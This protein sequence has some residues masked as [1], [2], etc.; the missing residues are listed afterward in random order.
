MCWAST[1]ARDN[2]SKLRVW[3]ARTKDFRSFGAPFI[4]V[5]EAPSRH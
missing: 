1:T 3:A 2:F 5:G 4:Y